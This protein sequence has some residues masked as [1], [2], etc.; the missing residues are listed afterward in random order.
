MVPAAISMIQRAYALS[1]K[2][3]PWSVVWRTII[4]ITYQNKCRG[5][6]L[7]GLI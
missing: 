3:A 2:R 5:R 1:M 4:I 6:T 7:Y